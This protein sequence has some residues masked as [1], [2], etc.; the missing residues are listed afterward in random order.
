MTLSHTDMTLSRT[1]MTLSRTNMTLSHFYV[2]HSH[3][4]M[5]VSHDNDLASAYY[6]RVNFTEKIQVKGL[7]KRGRLAPRIFGCLVLRK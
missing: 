3:T 1:N 4:D 5:R 2:T 7:S 6:Q